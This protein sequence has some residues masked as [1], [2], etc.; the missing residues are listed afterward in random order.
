MFFIDSKEVSVLQTE[1]DPS[2][3][4]TLVAL[5]PEETLCL[6]GAYTFSVLQGSI[7]LSGVTISSSAKSYRV[8]AP[9][10]APLPVLEGV[11]HTSSIPNIHQLPQ[12]VQSV[13]STPVALVLLQ[14]L[15]SHVE[16]LGDI[17][18]TFDGV[19]EPSRLQK[20]AT[21][22]LQLSGVYMT[23]YAKGQIDKISD[24]GYSG[25]RN[26]CL[27]AKS[28]SIQVRQR[29]RIYASSQRLQEVWEEH[30]RENACQFIA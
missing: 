6:L 29:F 12:A 20:S 13:I 2:L 1:S 21:S 28:I 22:S 30:V 19:F 18:R 9:R 25:V 5:A 8:F 3:H 10:S 17:C 14:E 11:G 4:A 26:T 7:M 24:K 16:G 15:H 27:M 23:F